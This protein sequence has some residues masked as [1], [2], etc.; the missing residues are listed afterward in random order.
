MATPNEIDYLSRFG[1]RDSYV[2]GRGARFLSFAGCSDG[3]YLIL[4]ERS[5]PP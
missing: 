5:E 2:P 4:A 3:H 1:G